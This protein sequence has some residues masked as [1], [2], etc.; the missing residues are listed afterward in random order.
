MDSVVV[1]DDNHEDSARQ[2]EHKGAE[3]DEHTVA[4]LQFGTAEAIDM[5]V[6]KDANGES[7]GAVSADAVRAQLHTNGKSMY[8]TVL[9]QA[10]MQPQDLSNLKKT[11][12]PFET[13]HAPRTV[14]A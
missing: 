11:L 6:E 12:A 2:K 14:L 8:V 7:A 9:G 3:S 1:G 4:G 5:A 10:Y 13:P